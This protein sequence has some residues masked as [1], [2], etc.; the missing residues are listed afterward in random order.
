MNVFHYLTADNLN[1]QFYLRPLHSLYFARKGW[2]ST[3]SCSAAWFKHIS[4]DSI[5]ISSNQGSH[6]GIFPHLKRYHASWS[7]SKPNNYILPTSILFLRKFF[8]HLQ[9]ESIFFIFCP[10]LLY[11]FKDLMPATPKWSWS[12]TC[13]L[14]W[15]VSMLPRGNMLNF[16]ILPS[17]INSSRK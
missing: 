15:K 4:W 16:R 3:L 5:F 7:N 10:G 6:Y 9:M 11:T 1:V 8:P 14:F 13:K 2:R 17:W 12:D